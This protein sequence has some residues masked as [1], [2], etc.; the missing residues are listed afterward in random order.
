MKKPIKILITIVIIAAAI[1][2]LLLAAQALFLKGTPSDEIWQSSDSFDPASA[3]QLIK[4]DGEDFT[5]L[6]LADIQLGTSIK[7]DKIALE[8]MD[9]LV[10]ET[11][12]DFIMTT[13]DNSYFL[14]ADIMT[15]KA[16]TPPFK[17]RHTVEHHPGQPRHRQ[18]G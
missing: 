17:L 10:A 9:E 13:G 14:I 7:K 3:S 5:I 11:N 8:I 18:P 4:A 6:L 12:P 1:P 2:A 16:I 15:K